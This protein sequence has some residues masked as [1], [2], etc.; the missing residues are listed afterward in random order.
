M[1]EEKNEL[2]LARKPGTSFKI[3]AVNFWKSPH[4]IWSVNAAQ[5]FELDFCL[6]NRTEKVWA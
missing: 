2:I 4:G 1:K 3:L 5:N 6:E